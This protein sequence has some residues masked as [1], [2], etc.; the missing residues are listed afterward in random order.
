M[1][2]IREIAAEN[3]PSILPLL[4]ELRPHI[5]ADDLKTI[6]EQARRADGFTFYGYYEGSRCVGLMGLRYLTD[7]V[8]KFHLY[9]DDLV[10]TKDQR[11][12]GVGAKLLKFAEELA[13]EKNCSG[14]RLCTGIENEAGKRFYERENWNL[15]A[16]V[17]KK[18][19]S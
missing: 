11:S 5:T 8:H 6:Y 1:N 9:I 19:I 17:Y 12:S 16:I 4:Q 3:V 7:F 18:K 13:K 10:V 2:P 14:L 15:R